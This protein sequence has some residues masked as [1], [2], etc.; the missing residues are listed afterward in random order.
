MV[1][2]LHSV[3]T[4]SRDR[5]NVSLIIIIIRFPT[6]RRVQPVQQFSTYEL[7]CTQCV[8]CVYVIIPFIL[9]DRPVDA[10]AGI[11]REEGHT[12]F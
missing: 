10:P 9:D 7:A 1:C 11:T 2:S 8:F 4:G 3:T 12:V 5:A 6:S